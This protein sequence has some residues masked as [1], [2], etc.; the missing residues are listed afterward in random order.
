LFYDFAV[1]NY[2]WLIDGGAF[3]RLSVNILSC[4]FCFY[5]FALTMVNWVFYDFAL[6]MVNWVFYDFALTMVNWVFYDFALTMVNWE[7]L[8]LILP[9]TFCYVS[10][11]VH[12]TQG[13]FCH[14]NG[15]SF[16]N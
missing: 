9:L 3:C 4:K 2:G 6:T 15:S 8:L 1:T 7:T 10:F 12:E 11:R 13:L 5:D 16:V 14:A